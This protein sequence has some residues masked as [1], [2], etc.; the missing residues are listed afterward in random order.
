MKK[1]ISLALFGEGD[2]YAQYLPSFVRA[3]ANIFPVEE[4][5]QLCIHVDRLVAAT[6]GALL[7]RYE[8]AGIL[9][10]TKMESAPLAKAMLWRMA[11]IF[12]MAAGYVFCRDID[13]VPMPR[14][15][16]CC[17]AF[18]HSDCT[19]HTIHDNKAHTGIMGGLCGFY[20]PIFKTEMGVWSFN[21]LLFY[22]KKTT[23]EW[24]K[25]GTDQD[26]LNRLINRRGGPAVCEHRFSGWFM[27]PGPRENAAVPGRYGGGGRSALVPD[28]WGS[29][30]ERADLLGSH[31]GCA[32]Y[33]HVAARA[34]WDEHGEAELTRTIA[35]CEDA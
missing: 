2:R 21:E 7:Q 16:A 35:A 6:Y 4:G 18:M 13:A 26:V 17:E 23:E 19:V 33:D 31:L 15:R 22:A 28:R 5:W 32:G 27:G 8:E 20:A 30:P 9:A 3:H 11:P 24:S 14:D 12:H 34:F 10:I 1:V 25:H 29:W